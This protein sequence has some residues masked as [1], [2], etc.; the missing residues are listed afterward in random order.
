MAYQILTIVTK[1]ATSSR[2]TSSEGG[3]AVSQQL[4]GFDFR[5][6]ADYAFNAIRDNDTEHELFSIIPIKLYKEESE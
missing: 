3:V 4:I 2:V 5:R 1:I 6:D